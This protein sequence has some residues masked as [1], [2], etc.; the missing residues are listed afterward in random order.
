MKRVLHRVRQAV[1]AT[2]VDAGFR[3]LAG[4]G[5]RT[6]L[7][8][9]SRHGVEVI[10]DVAYMH[11]PRGGVIEEHLLDVWRPKERK[12]PLPVVLYVHGGGFRILSKDTHWVMALAFA[13]RGYL[14]FNVSY[15]LAPRHPFPAALEDLSH[16]YAWVS[17]H[18][19]AYGGDPSRFVLAGESAGANLVSVLA[20]LSSYKRHEA[21]AKRI[22]DSGM[23]PRA[24][25]P[26]CGIFQVSDTSRFS[27][28]RALPRFLQDRLWE[29][30]HAYL[31]GV[32]KDDPRRELADPVVL[33]ERGRKPDRAL[34]PFFLSVGTKDPLL[35]D[36]RRLAAA[37]EHL[38]VRAEARY[39]EGEVHAFQ[40][41]VWR[42]AAQR[43][44]T[45]TY[46]FLEDVIG[47]TEPATTRPALPRRKRKTTAKTVAHRH[48]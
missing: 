26:Q 7:A 15:R 2:V 4:V 32:A 36:T 30:E 38:G 19:A 24:V 42:R 47:P 28:R 46:A 39:F 44:W 20:L 43:C 21:F 17:T 31:R 37:L 8:R 41:L 1:G 35:D 34:P 18:A 27:R 14:V 6:P 22:W 10:R 29:V 13:R 23:H 5:G 16:A 9:P 40:A 48:A 25:I 45:E 12:G 11:G 33:L 3:S